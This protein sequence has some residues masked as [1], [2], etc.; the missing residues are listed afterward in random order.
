MSTV[1][2]DFRRVKVLSNSEVY[3]GYFLLSFETPEVIV[4]R[5]GQFLQLRLVDK[6]QFLRRPFGIFDQRDKSID[7]FYKVRGDITTKM[8]ALKAEDSL[9]IICPLG[10]GFKEQNKKDLVIVSGG[11]GF[12]PL[13]FLAKRLSSKE[14]LFI[15][16]SAG[17]ESKS[18]TKLVKSLDLDILI[19][20]EDGSVGEQGMVTDYL[21]DNISS[22]SIIYSAG[23]LE[24]LK[25]VYKIA[26]DKKAETQFSFESHFACGMGFCWGCAL[27]TKNGTVRVCSEGPVFNGE[28]VLWEEL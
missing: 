6:G 12:A 25:K 26:K 24:M 15:I 22:N 2:K 13:N 11:T 8:S 17:S 20:S 4:V 1:I 21:V 3:P 5:P 10:N 27:K 19:V 16:G 18:F 7:I 28:D 14:G 23:P 9:D